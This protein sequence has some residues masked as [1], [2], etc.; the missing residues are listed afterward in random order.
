[1]STIEGYCGNKEDYYDS[2]GHCYNDI[3]NEELF[4]KIYKRKETNINSKYIISK[5]KY[6]DIKNNIKKYFHNNGKDNFKDKDIDLIIKFFT[7]EIASEIYN[8]GI[9]DSYKFISNKLDD[10]LEI[11]K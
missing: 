8:Q 3:F 7:D 1:M 5:E 10:L 4:L 11:Q 9:I 2:Q 6:N